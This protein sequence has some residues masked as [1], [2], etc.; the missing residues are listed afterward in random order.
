MFF[1]AWKEAS[2][3]CL[4]IWDV[5]DIKEA[6]EA[7]LRRIRTLSS[8]SFFALCYGILLHSK[9]CKIEL[10]QTVVAEGVCQRKT[11]W[12][13]I[14]AM[15]ITYR[16]NCPSSQAWNRNNANITFELSLPFCEFSSKPFIKSTSAID[17]SH[18]VSWTFF[19]GKR[20]STS[21]FIALFTEE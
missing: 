4:W 2:Q 8:F 5:Q 13:V 6:N 17:L 7:V 3:S 1:K 19:L 18:W 14:L 9:F 10:N 16:V 15:S 20:L 21:F 11:W 12:F